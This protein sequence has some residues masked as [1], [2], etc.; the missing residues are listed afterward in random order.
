MRSVF[1]PL[2][3]LFLL[4]PLTAPAQSAPADEYAPTA[5]TIAAAS[6]DTLTPRNFSIP[7]QPLASALREFTRQSGVGVRIE[8]EVPAVRTSGVVGRFTAPEALR[9]LIAGTGLA[10][11]VLDAETLA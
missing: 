9:Q 2:S 5:M 1:S 8:A 4:L 11:E 7:P 10:V 6:S 3:A